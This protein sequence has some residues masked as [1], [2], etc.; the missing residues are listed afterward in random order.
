LEVQS[1]LLSQQSLEDI[2]IFDD[3]VPAKS[4]AGSLD[5]STDFFLLEDVKIDRRPD[6]Y[7][8]FQYSIDL[9]SNKA[10]AWIRSL[11]F[12]PADLTDTFKI[13]DV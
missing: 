10:K 1:S 2:S 13:N 3:K 4:Q 12:L 5:E 9:V 8:P 11:Y 6:F 7:L